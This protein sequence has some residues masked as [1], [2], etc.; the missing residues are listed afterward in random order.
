[1]ARKT[2][3]QKM[4]FEVFKRDQFRCFYCG[5]M[6]PEVVLQVDHIIAIASGGL[7][8]PENMVTACFDCNIGKGARPLTAV[9]ENLAERMERIKE[10]HQQLQ[11][12]AAAMQAIQQQLDEMAWE[13]LKTIGLKE[14]DQDG[15]VP[16][17]WHNGIKVLLRHTGK[18]QLMEFAAYIN[19]NLPRKSDRSKFLCFAKM[20]WN[21]IKGIS[22]LLPAM[23]A[24]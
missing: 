10:T 21:H 6:P 24:G 16:T 20:A 17:D 12:Y 11:D 3:T 22:P 1:M 2:I 7:N 9:P 18:E 14:L 13:I 23:S 8:V 5:R 15:T 19:A 4:R